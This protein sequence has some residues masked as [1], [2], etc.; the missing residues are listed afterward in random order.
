M[1]FWFSIYKAQTEKLKIEN[2]ISEYGLQNA[3][4]LE[5][6]FERINESLNTSA[7][8]DFALELPTYDLKLLYCKDPSNKIPFEDA[9]YGQQAGSILTI[10]LN[11][12]IE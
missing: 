3:S 5:T 9:S 4:L 6:D 7:I 1:K 2:I 12:I 10:L 11:Q 8:I